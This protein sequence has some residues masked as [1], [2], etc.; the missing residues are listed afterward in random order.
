MFASIALAMLQQTNSLATISGWFGGTFFATPA[1]LTKTGAVAVAAIC[2]PTTMTLYLAPGIHFPRRLLAPAVRRYRNLSAHGSLSTDGELL[3]FESSANQ[4]PR[5]RSALPLH[6]KPVCANAAIH[7]ERTAKTAA[8]IG[9]LGVKLAHYARLGSN[10]AN[11][12]KLGGGDSASAVAV[13][14]RLISELPDVG[15]VPAIHFERARGRTKLHHQSID[16]LPHILIAQARGDLLPRRGTPRQ[17]G[18]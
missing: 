16:V 13:D 4:V 3:H 5:G 7:A 12:A 15:G 8:S 18:A 11:L 6:S 9:I 10:H 2:G 14:V 1:M 17:R